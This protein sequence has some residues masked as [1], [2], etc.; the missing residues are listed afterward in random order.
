MSDPEGKVFFPGYTTDIDIL[1]ENDN[2]YLIEIKSTASSQDIAHFLQ[3]AK[4][5]E[6]IKG[7]KPTQLILVTLRIT[8]ATYSLAE[9]QKIRTIAGEIF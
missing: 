1:L 3:N 2:T 8:Q 5:F 6:K 7:K 4:L 9:A